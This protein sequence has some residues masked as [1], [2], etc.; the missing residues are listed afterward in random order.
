MVSSRLDLII[1]RILH[2]SMHN[3]LTVLCWILRI[4]ISHADK[5]T[6][7][8]IWIE[9]IERRHLG[10]DTIS[11]I[12]RNRHRFTSHIKLREMPSEIDTRVS[13]ILTTH[14]ILTIQAQKCIQSN[15]SHQFYLTHAYIR[16]H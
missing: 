15:T 2:I 6:I 8:L 9:I 14:I 7:I 3:E 12:Q 4:I 5:V 10:S 11:S 13:I 16:F 1:G